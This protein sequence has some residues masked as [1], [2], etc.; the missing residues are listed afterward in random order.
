MMLEKIM[1]S[2]LFSGYTIMSV[3]SDSKDPCHNE[4]EVFTQCVKAHPR[5]LKETD[6]DVEKQAFRQC[7][8]EW[9]AKMSSN[10]PVSN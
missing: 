3:S 1:D 4:L 10:K 8:K 7:M 2:D 6:C 5:G 9:K